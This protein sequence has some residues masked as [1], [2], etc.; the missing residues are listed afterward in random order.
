MLVDVDVV[1]KGFDNVTFSFVDRKGGVAPGIIAGLQKI[2][3]KMPVK[4]MTFI[5]LPQKY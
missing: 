2:N 3:K 1:A 5:I 4:L